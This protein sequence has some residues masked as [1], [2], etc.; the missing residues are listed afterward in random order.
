M[1][2][3]LLRSSEWEAKLNNHTAVIDTVNE[4]FCEF[5]FKPSE[6]MLAEITNNYSNAV[7]EEYENSPG[8]S[9]YKVHFD[10]AGTKGE[11]IY[12]TTLQLYPMFEDFDTEDEY[13]RSFRSRLIK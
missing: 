7:I 2:T 1:Q 6:E 8:F 9:S 11:A 3:A 13:M 10:I 4:K 5:T 12:K